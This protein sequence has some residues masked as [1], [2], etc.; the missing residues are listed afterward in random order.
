GP[1][2]VSVGTTVLVGG[3]SYFTAIAGISAWGYFRTKTELDFVA[4]GRSIGPF[5]GGAVLAATQISAGTFVG[6][7]GRH[8]LAGVSWWYV[9]F[10]VWAGWLVSAFWWHPSSVASAR[11]RS[12]T[13]SPCGS[14]AR[15]RGRSPGR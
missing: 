11:S 13:T 6:T 4:A 14:A 7:V 2:A 15:R 3:S 8:Y 12:P 1:G 10:G 9:W 5:V